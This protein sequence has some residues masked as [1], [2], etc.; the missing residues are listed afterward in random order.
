[1]WPARPLSIREGWVAGSLFAR[2]DYPA[3]RPGED[4][5]LG[6]IWSFD[7]V[8]MAVVLNKLDQIEGT[9]QAN[10]ADLYH[11][12]IFDVFDMTD[13]LIGDAFGYRYAIDPIIDGFALMRPAADERY[14][15]WPAAE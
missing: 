8:E 2:A 10:E 1:M 14:V 15:V 6:E 11:R 3:M 12:V 13:R 7:A 4:R 9:N 5:V